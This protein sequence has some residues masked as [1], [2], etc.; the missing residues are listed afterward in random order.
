MPSV[1]VSVVIDAPLDLVWQEVADLGSHPEWM[2]DADSIRFADEQRRGVG[3]TM[4]VAT[5]L[6]P[7]RASDWLVVTAWEEKRLIEVAHVG[8]VGGW[9][10]FRLDPL[11][12]GVRF[13]WTEELRFPLWLV[14]P[15]TAFVAQ[16]ILAVV[17]R[18]NLALFADRV[19]KRLSGR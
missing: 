16:W 11:A 13:T 5:R 6:G 19:G 8:T 15:V 17:W 1:S 14:G 9:G 12:G 18:R 3:T 2:A 4:Q 7:L 10:R